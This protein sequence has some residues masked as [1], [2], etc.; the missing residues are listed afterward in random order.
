LEY[1]SVDDMLLYLKQDLKAM[2]KVLNRNKK[3]L[4]VRSDGNERKLMNVVCG[5][6]TLADNYISDVEKHPENYQMPKN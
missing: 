2:Q 6:G 5:I 4:M 3:R 1:E